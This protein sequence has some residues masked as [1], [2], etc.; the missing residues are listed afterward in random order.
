MTGNKIKGIFLAMASSASF[1][2][3]PL[4]SKPLLADGINTESICLYRFLLGT[5]I[6]GLF[7]WIR[8][9]ILKRSEGKGAS[10]SARLAAKEIFSIDWKGFLHVLFASIL[11]GATAICLTA[12]YK[13]IDSGL[14]TTIHFLY[15]VFIAVIMI[16]FYRDRITLRMAMC[17]L[18]SIVGVAALSG[19][20]S[21]NISLD[22]T[23]VFLVLVAT[24]TYSLY[25]V[26]VN[27]SSTLKRVKGGKLSFYVL[28][29]A[30]FW[31]FVNA[32][33]H[34]GNFAV[35]ERAD[36]WFNILMLALVPTL[37]ANLTLIYAIQYVGSTVTSI[38][39][40][41]EPLTAVVVGVLYFKEEISAVQYGGIIVI[42]TAVVLVLHS[43]AKK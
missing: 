40:C 22:T 27:V 7:L 21:G 6:L 3:I 29:C 13:Y 30:G 2:F 14:G 12:S 35:L 20:S 32:L 8:S 5:L 19:V 34:G 39:G 26:R 17:I 11:Y 23:G 42:V 10:L 24:L 31:F 1:G 15:P 16:V 4:F 43:A 33:L 41:M 28:F 25:I 9:A 36:Q 18:L 37:I 38:L